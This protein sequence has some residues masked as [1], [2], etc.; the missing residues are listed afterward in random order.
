MSA[1][2]PLSG[3]E[4]LLWATGQDPVLRSTF[5]TVSICDRPPDLGRMRAKMLS[6]VADIP[7]LAQR[8]QPAAHPLNVPHWVDD[9]GFD[10]SFHVRRAAL[11]APGSQRQLLDLAALAMEDSFDPHRPLWQFTLVEGLEDGRGALVAKLHHSLTDGVGGV[12]L[13]ASFVDLERD[14]P[15]AP[16]PSKPGRAARPAPRKSAPLTPA[17][18]TSSSSRTSEPS[19]G[20]ALAG[21]RMGPLALVGAARALAGQLLVTQPACSPMW[22]G[23][24]S[25]GRHLETTQVDLQQTKD[26]AGRL[27]ATLNDLFVAG[28]AGGA[29]AYHR[30]HGLEVGDLR[31]SMPVSTRQDRSAGGNAFV[32]TRVLVPAG[33]VGAAQRVAEV[34]RRLLPVRKTSGLGAADTIAGVVARLPGPWLAQVAIQQVGTVDFAA[35][36]VRGAPFDLYMGGALV[37]ASYPMGPTGGT[38]FNATL[39]SYRGS[40]DIGITTDTAAI[41]DP[42]LLADCIA[43]SLEELVEVGRAAPATRA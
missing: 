15:Q 32:P 31:V 40:V 18:L 39:L 37:L 28:V 35:S 23:L 24:R 26:A 6:A 2:L 13:S 3:T 12:R 29:G 42:A 19:P 4:A 14:S 9:P 43:A 36:N 11:P 22:S 27:G 17:S 33:R 38:A 20:P 16:N 7:R 25:P 30:H 21:P 1:A 34:H 41:D 8:V 10:I 5:L